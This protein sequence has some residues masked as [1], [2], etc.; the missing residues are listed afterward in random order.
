MEKR[1]I[2]WINLLSAFSQMWY[3][4]VSPN[5]NWSKLFKYFFNS[6]SKILLRGLQIQLYTAVRIIIISSGNTNIKITTELVLTLVEKVWM[7]T[8]LASQVF[9]WDLLHDIIFYQAKPLEVSENLSLLVSILSSFLFYRQKAETD[10]TGEL[11]LSGR[12][13]QIWGSSLPCCH[14]CSSIF[15]F[16]IP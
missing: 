3:R 2:S 7:N 4:K 13:R 8:N 10:Q 15:W 12:Q 5:I 11:E 6:L 9:F 14:T 16:S 1:I